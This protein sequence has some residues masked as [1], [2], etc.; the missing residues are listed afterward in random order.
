MEYF[1][2]DDIFC[3]DLDDLIQE[4]ELNDETIN[5]LSDDWKIV[6]EATTLQPIFQ[7]KKEF[8]VNCIVN[9]TDVWEDRFPVNSDNTFKQI[10]KAIEQGIDLEQINEQLPR[11]YYPN[12]KKFEITKQD[13][14]DYI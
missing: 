2:Y 10:E 1:F 7:F 12:G 4:L 11:L 9:N 8:I 14:L 5:D 3:Q 13:L 6:V